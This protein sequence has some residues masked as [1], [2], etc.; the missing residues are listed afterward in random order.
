MGKQNKEGKEKKDIRY[1]LALIIDST[2]QQIWQATFTKSGIIL[3]ATSGLVLFIAIIFSIIAFTPVRTLIP[4]YPDAMTKRMAVRNAMKID[5]LEREI[6]IWDIYSKNLRNVLTGGIPVNFDSLVTS[7]AQTIRQSVDTSGFTESDSLLRKEISEN[8]KYNVAS[9][10]K[11]IKSIEGKMF[12]TPAKGVITQKYNPSIGH[13]FIDIACTEG[14]T[15]YSIL[16]GTVISSGWND[17]TGYTIQ[18]QHPDDIVSVYKH[19]G[20]LLKNVGDKVK[21]GTPI[22]LTG[23]TGS[24]STGPHLHFELW[25]AGEAIDPEKYINF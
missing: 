18:I 5:S 16:E 20:K 21:A 1:R 13:P 9:G 10:M 23:N 6:A 8:E 17:E 12:Y 14:A 2:H 3:I 15:V 24:L 22:A 19:N 7:S 4:G 11:D 25:H